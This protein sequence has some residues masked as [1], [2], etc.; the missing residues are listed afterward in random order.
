LIPGKL[1]PPERENS[2]SDSGNGIGRNKDGIH[3]ADDRR[4]RTDAQPEQGLP[5]R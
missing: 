2:R 4:V 5:R 3:D 1:S